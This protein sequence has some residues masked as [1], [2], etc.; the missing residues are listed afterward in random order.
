MRD[1][2]ECE[3]HALFALLERYPRLRPYLGNRLQIDL[4]LVANEPGAEDSDVRLDRELF[5]GY[6][7]QLTRETRGTEGGVAA[8]IRTRA[9]GVQVCQGHAGLL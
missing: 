5:A 7:A 2:G 8:K 6:D 9:I 4:R 1:A 3:A